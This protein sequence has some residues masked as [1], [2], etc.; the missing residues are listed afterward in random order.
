MIK[1]FSAFGLLLVCLGALLRGEGTPIALADGESL[2]YRVRWG[3]FAGAGEIVVEAKQSQTAGL[4][5][6][7]ISTKT[8]T[9]GFVRSLYQFDGDSECVFD[10]RDGRLLAIKATTASSRKS[11]HTMAVFDHE[12]DK[13]QYVDYIRPERNGEL[14]LPGGNPMDLITCLIQTRT[15]DLK[16]GDRSPALVMFDREFYD[17]TV[18]AEGYERVRTPMGEYNTLIL[19]PTMEKDPKGLFKRGGRVRVWISQDTL[20]L[21]VKF[22]VSMKV[23]TGVAVLAEY[24]PPVQGARVATASTNE[25]SRP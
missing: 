11:T 7:N 22:E 8:N 17:L 3:L 23:G 18:V 21:P 9:R 10:A 2:K 15:W 5:Q 12:E 19:V 6:I 4:P 13:V 16:P 20:K 24:T 1:R 25:N 14:P